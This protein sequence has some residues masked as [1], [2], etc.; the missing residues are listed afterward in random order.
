MDI[1]K[2]QR[3]EMKDHTLH[4]DTEKSILLCKSNAETKNVWAKKIHDIEGIHT[5]IEDEERYYLSC[6]YGERSGYFL[7][8]DRA[9]GST[10]WYIPGL[11]L[12]NV[13]F[14]GYLFLIFIDDEGIYYLLKVDRSSGNKAWYHR[15]NQDLAEYSFRR[16]RILLSYASGKVEKLSPKTGSLLL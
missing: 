1:L 14:E 11:S 10:A 4:Y 12:F 15:I 3:F 6:E 16:D 7:A 8:V 2:S 9:N 5:V 13:I